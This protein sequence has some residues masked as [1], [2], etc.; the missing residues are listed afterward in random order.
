VK[1]NTVSP[2]ERLLNFVRQIYS[3]KRLEDAATL[4]A[5][6]IPDAQIKAREAIYEEFRELVLDRAAGDA[7]TE[8]RRL[9]RSI[10]ELGRRI[11]DVLS[12]MSSEDLSSFLISGTLKTR[13]ERDHPEEKAEVAKYVASKFFPDERAFCFVQASITSI[14]LAKEL[15]KKTLRDGSL[16]CTNSIVIPLLLLQGHP[17]ISV[18]TLCGTGYDN[19]CGGWLPSHNDEE[20]QR[21]LRD[22]F[23]RAQ[24]FLRDS[25]VTPIAVTTTDGVV[26]FTAPDIIALVEHLTQLSKSL[27]IMTY[28]SRVYRNDE[29]ARNDPKFVN[30]PLYP[31]RQERGWL[32]DGG[33]RA[34][35]IVAHDKLDLRS[36]QERHA[37]IRELVGA[38]FDVHWQA[39]NLSWKLLEAPSN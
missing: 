28:S 20:A 38:G 23:S 17:K 5:Q 35:L 7:S 11:N 10:D 12:L 26:Y 15:A 6:G 27:V 19:L 2:T 33:K 31:V 13:F 18:Y 4:F 22:S 36:A 32:M 16:I 34:Q 14:H 8:F 39:D 37:L 29:D 30:T 1:P 9:C 24:N 21:Y 3:T 25:F